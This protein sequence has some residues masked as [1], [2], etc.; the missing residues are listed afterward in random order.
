[1]SKKSI[2]G[3]KDENGIFSKIPQAPKQEADE[4]EISH[5]GI[6]VDRISWCGLRNIKGIMDAI[7]CEV[8]SKTF[9]RET[10]QNLKDVMALLRDLKKDERDYLASLKDEELESKLNDNL[11]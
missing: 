10:V 3:Y 8:G 1:M 6:S 2:P 7:T 11:E 4:P 9:T 5:E